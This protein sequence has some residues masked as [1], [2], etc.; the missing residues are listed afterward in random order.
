M[1]FNEGISL[2]RV[3]SHYA[4]LG[5][6]TKSDEINKEERRRFIM[7]EFVTGFL[8]LLLVVGIAIFVFST[9]ELLV[10][11]WKDF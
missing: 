2:Y 7:N 8:I 1:V 10:D 9:I 5:L 4:Y 3:L 6:E 11:I